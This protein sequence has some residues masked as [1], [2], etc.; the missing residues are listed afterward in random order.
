MYQFEAT[1]IYSFQPSALFASIATAEEMEQVQVYPIV[2]SISGPLLRRKADVIRYTNAGFK[3]SPISAR[4]AKVDDQS[5]GTIVSKEIGPMVYID[6][7][8]DKYNDNNGAYQLAHGRDA[9]GNEMIESNMY[10]SSS[11]FVVGP[12]Q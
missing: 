9:E 1:T 11:V 4:F 10:S 2:N 7:V 6:W 3:V 12:V 5:I 8:E